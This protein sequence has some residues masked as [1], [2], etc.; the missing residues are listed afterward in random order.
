[1][2]FRYIAGNKITNVVRASNNVLLYNNLPIVN[3][4][5]ESNNDTI[6]IDNINSTKK[7][8][9]NLC[10][11]LDKQDNSNH[12]YKIAIKLSQFNFNYDAIKHIVEMYSRNNIKILVD[13]ENNVLY[14]RYSDITNNLIDKYNHKTVNIYKT[15]QMYRKDSLNEL[16]NDLK[17][18]KKY[19]LY[20]GIK[21]VRGAYFNTEKDDGHLYS[22]KQDTDN[23]YN[24]AI[25]LIMHN[26]TDKINVIYATHNYDS[27]IKALELIII[28][29]NKTNNIMKNMGFA[30]L[31]GMN[32]V[33]MN[34]RSN[35]KNRY[36]YSANKV[37]NNIYIPYG[38]YS[39]MLPYLSRRLYENDSMFKYLL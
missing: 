18:T 39:Y 11:A 10:N 28:N 26:Y 1:M 27:I 23:N 22:V 15:Y 30:S 38:P 6:N 16:R 37:Q 35:S 29:S 34:I 9:T 8:Y 21:L 19:N 31:Y 20:H 13:A 4:I 2:L 33:I 17:Y 7:E 25:D 5:Y 3:Y 14:K 36:F 32:N 24:D 12:S